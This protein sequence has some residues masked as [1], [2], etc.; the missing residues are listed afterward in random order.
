MSGFVS[1]SYTRNQL[2]S[3]SSI[4]INNVVGHPYSEGVTPVYPTED[5]PIK[6]RSLTTSDDSFKTLLLEILIGLF[7][8]DMHLINNV[9]EP[10]GDV[11]LTVFDLK[12]LI[13]SLTGSSKVDII[14]EPLSS[15][16][17]CLWNSIPL[18][19]FIS[20]IKVD[21]NDFNIT[22]NNEYNI[23]VNHKICLTKVI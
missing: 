11:I 18:Y 16:C 21:G 17:N 22:H 14:T 6:S 23:L 1:A 15:D 20:K 3:D 19:K 8:Q 2:A 12:S 13:V 7:S 4:T 9:I 5:N 10:T